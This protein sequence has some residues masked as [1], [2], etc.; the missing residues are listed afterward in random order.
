MFNIMSHSHSNQFTIVYDLPPMD[1]GRQQNMHEWL[2]AALP[3]LVRPFA[4][5]LDRGATPIHVTA[6]S[7]DASFRRYYRASLDLA[8]IDQADQDS[9]TWIIMDAPPAQEATE[10]F[11]RIAG[12]LVGA[13]VP[14]PEVLAWDEGNGFMLLEDFGDQTMLNALD[15]L[16]VEQVRAHYQAAL[17]NLVVMQKIEPRSARL[18][19]YDEAFLRREMELFRHWLLWRHLG[20][21]WS[22]ADERYWQQTMARLCQS[23]LEQPQVFVHR[24]YHSRNLMI[25]ADKAPG[26][27]DFQDAM[28]GP[29]LYDVVSLLKDCYIKLNT[30]LRDELL[31]H[32]L[33][34]A[35]GNDMSRMEPDAVR[36]GFDHIGAQRQ[37]KAAGIFA[38]LYHRDGK[39]GYLPDV[40]RTLSYIVDAAEYDHDL[41]WLAELISTRV[42]PVLPKRMPPT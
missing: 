18:P 3:D 10:P 40:P 12:A 13:N 26:V 39:A 11:Y 23:A 1:P 7:V 25:R 37:L 4:Q 28:H 16:S 2:L 32:Y 36:K 34:L 15:G 17:A 42:L 31:D 20:R 9:H 6:A 30:T 5:H 27:I 41:T 24:D 33:M 21:S 19:P 38:R 14:A 29:M 22:L 8:Q 35:E